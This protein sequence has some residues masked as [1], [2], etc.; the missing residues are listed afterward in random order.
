MLAMCCTP[1]LLAAFGLD[2]HDDWGALATLRSRQLARLPGI[3]VAKAKDTIALATF[4]RHGEAEQPLC[5]SK[6]CL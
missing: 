6:S 2:G 4:P 1:P 3:I 5:T